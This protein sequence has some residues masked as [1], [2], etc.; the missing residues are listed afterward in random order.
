[1]KV[2]ATSFNSVGHPVHDQLKG[3]IHCLIKLKNL[4]LQLQLNGFLTIYKLPGMTSYQV[5]EHILTCNIGQLSP[6]VWG[7]R[8]CDILTIITSVREN[9]PGGSTNFLSKI[10]SFSK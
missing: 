2:N 7:V 5:F 9:Q 1:M 4:V 10:I 8:H 6:G 3:L